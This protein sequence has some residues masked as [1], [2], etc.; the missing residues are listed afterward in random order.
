[1]FLL[2][3]NGL[4]L[5]FQ[6]PEEIAVENQGGFNDFSHAIEEFDAG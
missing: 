5:L 2:C 1:L 3:Q 6:K 4:A